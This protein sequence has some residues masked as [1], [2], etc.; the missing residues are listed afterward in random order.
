MT[1]NTRTIASFLAVAV[2]GMSL[3]SFVTARGARSEPAALPTGVQMPVAA[4][5]GPA[6]SLDDFRGIARDATPGVVN[7]NTSKTVR[8]GRER[9][10]LRDLFGEDG[11]ERFFGNPRNQTQTSLGSG[12]VID[13]DGYVLTNRHVVEGADKIQVTLSDGR[14]TYDA[15]LVGKDARTDVALLKIEPKAALTVLPLGDS[16][17]LEVAEWVMAIGSPFNLGNTVTVGVVSYKGR[18]LTLGTLGTSVDLIQTDA[19]INPG[20]S[21]GPLINTRG[22]VIGIN[23]LI[24]TQGAP[25]SAGVGFAVPINV[26]KGILGQLREKGRVVRGW[27]GLQIGTLSDDMARSFGLEDTKGALI[28]DLD[29]RGPALKAGLE[30]GDVVLLAD[31]RTIE[32]NGDLSSYV[33]SRP[34]GSIVELVISREGKRK[35]VKVTLGTFPEEDAEE[36]QGEERGASLGMTLRDLTPE[37]ARQLDL[38]RDTRGAV[39]TGVEAGEPAADAGLN[40]GDVIVSVNGEAV[41]DVDGF[42]R[43]I[44]RARPSGLA[45]LR[46]RRGSSHSFLILK[47]K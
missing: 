8:G 17:A 7:I 31:G 30:P 47:L 5:R 3:G 26:A 27:L 37:M 6:T 16:D 42:E 23:T 35:T 33:S 13:K 38:P 28:Q 11:L 9:N 34:P 15:K 21:G 18:P 36:T 24:I 41:D 29:P 2:A 25:Q 1:K 32:D 40:R 43:Q 19:S 46:I 20:N 10:Q 44:E 12:F 4:T 45:R 22:E 14:T 39:V